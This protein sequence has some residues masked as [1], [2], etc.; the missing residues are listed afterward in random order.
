VAVAGLSVLSE[1]QGTFT[2]D[3]VEY[4]ATAD[5]ITG[6][7]KITGFAPLIGIIAA[8][9]IVIGILFGA[10]GGLLKGGQNM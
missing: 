9:S 1:M 7:T 5:G 4:N 3:G 10:F 6:L 8:I 2:A